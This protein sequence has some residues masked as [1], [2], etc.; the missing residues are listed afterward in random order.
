[1]KRIVL[2]SLAL[3]ALPLSAC[4]T[5]SAATPAYTPTAATP[6][7]EEPVSNGTVYDVQRRLSELGYYRGP[8][9][10]VWGQE[11]RLAM[12]QFQHQRGLRITGTPTRQAMNALGLRSE[13]FMSGS[14]LPPPSAADELNRDE[15]YR[16]WR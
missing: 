2:I 4:T 8:I 13:S 3:A 15:A 16:Q 12:E 10:G 14:S 11:T 6:R 7:Y 9:D 1:M 5:R